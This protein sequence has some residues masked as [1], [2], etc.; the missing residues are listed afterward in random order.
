VDNR[1]LEHVTGSPLF[2]F[3]AA[4]VFA[5]VLVAWPLLLAIH[6]MSRAGA[7]LPGWA[8]RLH[9]YCMFPED[10]RSHAAEN[11]VEQPSQE[12]GPRD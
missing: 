5:L 4:A 1:V 9:D 12:A 6:V 7:K 3:K 8:R 11:A 2:R 10:R